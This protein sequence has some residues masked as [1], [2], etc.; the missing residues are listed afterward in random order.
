MVVK[1]TSTVH[2]FVHF[3]EDSGRRTRH[4]FCHASL[5]M[6]PYFFA[7]FL[8]LET[9]FSRNNYLNTWHLYGEGVWV[10]SSS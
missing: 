9:S 1:K 4:S 6:G 10:S 5:E 7:P 3:V 8:L 2:R